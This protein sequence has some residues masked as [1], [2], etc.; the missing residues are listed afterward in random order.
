MATK[1][2]REK[3]LNEKRS[4]ANR[5]KNI[6]RRAKGLERQQAFQAEVNAALQGPSS[7]QTF[8]AQE[9]DILADAQF[10]V[11]AAVRQ[12]LLSGK[13]E[14]AAKNLIEAVQELLTTQEQDVTLESMLP[15][16]E[17]KDLNAEEMADLIETAS[18]SPFPTEEGAPAEEEEIV[19][20]PVTDKEQLLADYLNAHK[21]LTATKNQSVGKNNHKAKKERGRKIKKGTAVLA[22]RR[23]AFLNHETMPTPVDGH[24]ISGDTWGEVLKDGLVTEAREKNLHSI[25]KY[26]ARYQNAVEEYNSRKRRYGRLM[27]WE[28]DD[29]ATAQN[30]VNQLNAKI[31]AADQE[32]QKTVLE[33]QNPETVT[34][35][36]GAL[37]PNVREQ[38][39]AIF[40][41]RF[42][43]A[44][45]EFLT[46]GGSE[47]DLLPNLSK[48]Y[49]DLRTAEEMFDV[50]AQERID[51][52]QLQAAH[53]TEPQ[54]TR[55]LRENNRFATRW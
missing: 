13:S 26:Q 7:T 1:S 23:T 47:E 20:T 33:I 5:G 43:A 17:E 51:H 27:S 55:R 15:I 35:A 4:R 12:Y 30:R 28:S 29:L 14:H 44:E 49:A 11:D 31:E 42:E 24:V 22:Q 8:A 48:R 16:L 25:L 41:A 32:F 2:K 19:Q 54:S 10:A 53:T 45:K 34:H 38:I 21:S 37:S 9:E 36:L 52:V 18:N 40:R 50:P 46:S 39:P 3:L 6:E